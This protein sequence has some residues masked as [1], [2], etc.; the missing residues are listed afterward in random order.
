M[1]GIQELSIVVYHRAACRAAAQ[2]GKAVRIPVNR[3]IDTGEQLIHDGI[4]VSVC[5]VKS[6]HDTRLTVRIPLLR[7]KALI[8]DSSGNLRPG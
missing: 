5:P 6:A 3:I 1:M 7:S 8:A 2:I 4:N